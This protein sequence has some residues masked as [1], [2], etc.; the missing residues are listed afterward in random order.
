MS[1]GASV[2]RIIDPTRDAQ[3]GPGAPPHLRPAHLLALLL[4]LTGS[5]C[6]TQDLAQPTTEVRSTSEERAFLAATVSG[7]AGRSRPSD[8]QQVR[9]YRL[10]D[11]S[12]IGCGTWDAPDPYGTRGGRAPFYVRYT[13]GAVT[14]VHLDDLTGY[15]PA[16]T[17]C[18]S[19]EA[20]LTSS[21][22][23]S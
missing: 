15:G 16:R 13:S 14:R 8:L 2:A 7:A 11:G 5:G 1:E 19:A 6:V 17:G 23:S 18:Q 9:I 21:E 10:P 20:R 12:R 3:P 22:S 4:A